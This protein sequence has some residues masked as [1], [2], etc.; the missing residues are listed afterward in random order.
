MY[1]NGLPISNKDSNATNTQVIE[2]HKYVC[3]YVCSVM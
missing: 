2:W 3:S 1:S